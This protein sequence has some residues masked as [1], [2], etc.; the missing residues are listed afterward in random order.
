MKFW[1]T[2]FFV[3]ELL[4]LSFRSAAY[5]RFPLGQACERL[6]PARFA[7]LFEPSQIVLP[8]SSCSLHLYVDVNLGYAAFLQFA[9]LVELGWFGGL[10]SHL[11]IHT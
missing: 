6:T 9:F 7:S 1:D 10:F 3:Q 4:A 11:R 2:F 5:P 8:D